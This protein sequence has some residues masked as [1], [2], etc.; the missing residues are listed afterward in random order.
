MVSAR[1]ALGVEVLEF[2]SE[3]QRRDRITVCLG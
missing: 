1:D 2:E 3:L